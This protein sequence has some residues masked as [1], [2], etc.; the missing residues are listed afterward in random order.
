MFSRT[1]RLLVLTLTLMLS[2]SA[3]SYADI[4][5]AAMLF[6]RI[7]PGARAAGL[8][9]AFVAIADD[10]T[11]SHWNPAGLG[12]FPL[13]ADWLDSEIPIELRPV[14]SI[15][16]VRRGSASNY[17]GYELWALTAKGLRRYDNR[18]WY[19]SELFSVPSSQ[20]LEQFVGRYF[21]IADE[22]MRA[23][24]AARVAVANNRGTAESLVALKDTVMASI[25]EDYSVR[26]SMVDGFD[27]LITGYG[28]C[29]LDWS[30]IDAISR[31][32]E[33][34]TKDGSLTEREM[35]RIN[36]AVE[37]AHLLYILEEINIPFAALFN[38]A[39]TVIESNGEV[40]LVGSPN[41]LYQYS[42]GSW[43]KLTLHDGLP[44]ENIVALK[45]FNNFILIG[46]DNGLVVHDGNT[47]RLLAAEEDIPSGPIMA[48]GGSSLNDIYVVVNNDLY[49]YDGSSWKNWQDYTVVLD[50]TRSTIADKFSLYN[51][52]VEKALYLSK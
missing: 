33:E 2:M 47:L 38:E 40:L 26:Q 48:M 34:G 35:D 5:D 10:A 7:A 36:V 32:F 6:L 45:S 12:S 31:H 20:T 1:I 28:E 16:G 27:S 14:T 18:Q 42:E 29:R 49:R 11:A 8:G 22:E 30:Y 39:P 43:T 37:R 24:I 4:S 44:S 3:V 25:P 15:T 17:L 41:G 51:T 50:D 13:A 21:S 52:E 9:E 23:E 19:S 46:T